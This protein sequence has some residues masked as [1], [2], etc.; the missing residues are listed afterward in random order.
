MYSTPSGSTHH[1]HRDWSRLFLS[2]SGAT[3]VLYLLFAL[4]GL[5][6]DPR[7]IT[8]TIVNYYYVLLLI[9]I[10]IIIIKH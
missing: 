5:V 4:M 9:I 6:D 8:L 7:Y 1:V 10:F 3:W 2:L